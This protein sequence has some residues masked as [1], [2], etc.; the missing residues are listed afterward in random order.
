[1]C[2]CHGEFKVGRVR[3]IS[4]L[5]TSHRQLAMVV[6]GML[7]VTVADAVFTFP[8]LSVTVSVTLFAPLSAAVK[9]LGETTMPAM[10]HASLLPASTSPAVM[11]ALPLWSS[12]MAM[13][14][15]STVG[16]VTSCTVTVAL[17][18]ALLSTG[19]GDGQV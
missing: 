3:R 8:L 16:N 10:P 14:L 11:V 17:P 5:P 15:A 4:L 1:M 9:L 12:S 6:A 13:L 18:V 19:V 2:A 7:T